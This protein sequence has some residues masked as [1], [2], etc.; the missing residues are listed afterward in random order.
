MSGP[1]NRNLKKGRTKGKETQ[2]RGRGGEDQGESDGLK[3]KSICQAKS[4]NKEEEK[5]Q[6]RRNL[7]E[8]K[9]LPPSRGKKRR[10][11]MYG[12]KRSNQGRGQ[13]KGTRRRRTRVTAG[14]VKKKSTNGTDDVALGET[15]SCSLRPPTEKGR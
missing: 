8:I 14:K 15:A 13:S 6:S 3:E 7:M 10:G 1:A 11:Q 12:V 5:Y 2:N 4:K 9:A